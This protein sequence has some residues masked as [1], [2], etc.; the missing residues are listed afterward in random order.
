[1]KTYKPV[2]GD[3]VKFPNGIEINYDE[4]TRSL[5][6]LHPDPAVTLT[7]RPEMAANDP[8]NHLRMSDG[9][10]WLIGTVT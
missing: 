9:T 3:V 1:M 10:L 6:V 8:D 2:Q 4:V 5:V 7:M